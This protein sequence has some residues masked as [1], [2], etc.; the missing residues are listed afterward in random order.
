VR[1]RARAMVGVV[2]HV[3]ILYR[4][5]PDSNSPGRVPLFQMPS[6]ISTPSC[7]FLSVRSISV[8]SLRLSP[9][10]TRCPSTRVSRQARQLPVR[11][12]LLCTT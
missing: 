2:D 10:A 11:V 6:K 5:A 9:I 4:G 7:T 3:A 1:E 8:C 12:F